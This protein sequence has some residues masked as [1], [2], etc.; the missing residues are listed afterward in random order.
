MEN[1]EGKVLE[2]LRHELD[3]IDRDL[4]RLLEERMDVCLDIAREK[5]R[6]GPVKRSLTVQRNSSAAQ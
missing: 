5:R 4:F 1:N 3:E 6:R 2:E